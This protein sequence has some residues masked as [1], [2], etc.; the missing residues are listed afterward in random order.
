[1]LSL[2]FYCLVALP[3]VLTGHALVRAE[4]VEDALDD[5]QQ[6]WQHATADQAGAEGGRL[7]GRRRRECREWRRRGG[8]ADAHDDGE[9]EGLI[10]GELLA[11]EDGGDEVDEGAVD[12]E[13]EALG[14]GVVVYRADIA[15]QLHR[16]D[17]RGRFEWV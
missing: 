5:A 13:V 2:F 7:A 15:E 14:A 8:G 1:V 9:V 17:L 10:N 6:W 4:V 16:L 12:I 3:I 11:V